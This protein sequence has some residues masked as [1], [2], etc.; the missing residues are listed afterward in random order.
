MDALQREKNL[1]FELIRFKDWDR[2]QLKILLEPGIQYP[3][4]LGQLCFLLPPGGRRRLLGVGAVG[5]GGQSQPGVSQQL[6][7]R[8]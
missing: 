3:W 6:K 7:N 2:E 8:V 1:L 5:A 4:L